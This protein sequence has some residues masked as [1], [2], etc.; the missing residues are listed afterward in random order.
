MGRRGIV[1]MGLAVLAMALL[2]G[3]GG[4]SGG[5]GAH[6][7]FWAY[8]EPG[9]TFAGAAKRCT[10]QSGGRYTIEFHALGNDP[11]TQRQQLVR[12][13]AAKDSSI[14]I[15]SM[16]VI[17]TAEFAEAGW[18]KPWPQAAA[19][20]VKQ[21]TLKGPLDTATYQGKL[22][23]APANSNTQLLWYRKDLVKG[24]APKTWD[25]LIATA[26]KM[27]KAGRIE[28]QGA[29]YEG[30]TVWFNSLIQ[31][32]GGQILDGPDKVSLAPQ[33]TEA[34]LGVM[35]KLANSK[36]A[37]PSLSSQKEDQNRLAFETGQAAF[38]VNYPFIY[39]SAKENAPDLFKNLGWAPYPAVKNPA[40]AGRKAPI[41]G[42]NWGVGGYTKHPQEAF[43]A[44]TCMRDEE[45]QKEF[46]L[47][48][49]L[50]PTLAALYD[51]K[52]FVKA[53]PFAPLIRKELQDAAVR[54]QTPLYSDVSLAI[55]KTISPP[56]SIDP[57]STAAKLR[58]RV[59]NA[60]ESKG[61]L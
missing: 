30:I 40:D 27:P 7:N 38:Q 45:N 46:A 55:Y 10:Q 19:D 58:D 29:Q 3:C 31:S 8:N 14:D 35:A 44:A 21:G 16:D 34:A 54:P 53:Y 6:L 57:K 5:Q 32:A 49:G 51:N 20:K 12:R 22:Y 47:K 59:K 42:F 24:E 25:D 43:D 13:L 41:G 1:L 52:E 33:P 11:D 50:P 4:S 56:A 36:A 37:D 26:E 60:L 39:P 48:G 18:I 23:A 15:M 9:G 28:I 17:W 61:L 2:A